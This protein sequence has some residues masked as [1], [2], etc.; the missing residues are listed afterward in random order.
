MG[1]LQGWVVWGG[2]SLLVTFSG[3]RWASSR[4]AGRGWAERLTLGGLVSTAVIVLSV[5]LCGAAGQLRPLPLACVS[6]VL[7]L[8]ILRLGWRRT[9]PASE[10]STEPLARPLREYVEPLLGVVPLAVAVLI[11]SA[12][13]VWIFKSW[14]WDATAYHVPII[15]H[16]I[17]T[18]RLGP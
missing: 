3:Q 12:V 15:N 7:S 14:N 11:A 9:L 4:F 18:G 5:Q 13:T 10:E 6:G 16:A 17:E 8:S 1:V 2:L